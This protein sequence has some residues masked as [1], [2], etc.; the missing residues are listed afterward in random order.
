[1]KC[2]KYIHTIVAILS[3]VIFVVFL[4]NLYSPYIVSNAIEYET[5]I[6]PVPGNNRITSRFGWRDLNGDGK[7][8][9]LHQAI[10][11]GC[12]VGTNV[13]AVASGKVV[14]VQD[15]SYNYGMGRRL[16]I[17]HGNSI[18]TGYQHLSKILVKTGDVV[19]QGDVIALSGNTG[20]N[21][22]PHLDFH[23]KINS[24]DDINS[25]TNHFNKNPLDNFLPYE[26]SVS[27][28]GET[29]YIKSTP[30][31]LPKYSEVVTPHLNFSGYE[32]LPT[33]KLSLG[34]SYPVKGIISAYPNINHVWGGV[35]N[36][37]GSKTA[38]YCDVTINASTYNLATYFDNNIIFNK[39]PV[40][41]Y[42]YKIE[43]TTTD[44][45]HK[46]IQ[47]EFQ[48]GD[49]PPEKKWY[50]TMTPAN[51]ANSFD[52]I[53]LNKHYWIPIRTISSTN[54]VLHKEEG[55]TSEMWRFTRQSD[56]SYKIENFGNG[57]CLDAWGMGTANGTN[58]GSVASNN[59]QAQR[60]FIYAVNG[61][62][63]FRPAYGELAMDLNGNNNADNTNIQLWTYHG[64]DAQVF[65]IYDNGAKPSPKV[66]KANAT[67]NSS[68]S[69][70]WD[71]TFYTDKYVVYRS[72]DNTNWKKLGE[73]TSTSYTDNGLSA[74]TKYYYKYESVN[75]FY[76]VSSPSVAVTT[77][78][79]PEYTVTFD[80]NG[81]SCSPT[82]KVVRVGNAYGD[83]P[84]ATR[85]GYTFNGWYTEKNGG[86]QVTKDTKMNTAKNHT[87]YAHWTANQYTLIV[88]PNGGTYDNSTS[89]VTKSPKLIYDSG[90]WYS[91]G[92]ATRTGY[93]LIGYFT[94]ATGGT[95]VYD[96]NG[97]C[98]E[99]DFWKDNK[100]K[101]T[102]NLTVYAQWS[103]I[104]NI[105]VTLNPNGGTCSKDSITVVYDGKYT[106]LVNADRKG[107]TFDGWY[108]ESGA[109]VTTDT[110]VKNP[111]AHTLYAHWTAKNIS[112]NFYR[113][114]DEND[115]GC[116]T[117]TFT[118][119]VANQRFGYKTD[120]TG[121]Y[122]PMNDEKVGFG[123]WTKTGYQLLGWSTQRN[124]SVNYSTYSG[125]ANDWI[126]SNSP[127]INLYAQWKANQY[128]VKLDANGGTVSSESITVTYDGTY[129]DLPD[130][131]Q[132]GYNFNGWFT[133]NGTQISNTDRVTIVSDLTLYAH[134]SQEKMLISFNAN[135]GTSETAK[136]LVTFD[137]KYGA[138]PNAT[139]TGYTFEGWYLDEKFTNLI[140]ES[141]IVKIT[142]NQAV[143]AKWNLQ[144][145]TVK[146]DANGGTAET[147]GKQ[148]IFSRTYGVLPIAEKEN[149]VFVGWFT[150][151][152][153]EIT[154]D[155]VV[156]IDK[157]ITLY[158][159]WQSE[160]KVE[161]DVNSDSVLDVNDV[162]VLNNYLHHK[163]S[164]TKEMFESADLNGDGKI[165]VID[166]ALLK[167][168]ILKGKGE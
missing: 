104:G 19:S 155:T 4:G 145:F 65:S 159:K 66:P 39:L 127:S 30:Y 44:G 112:V 16:V 58:I 50:E 84:N 152:G 124:S 140:T 154:P 88:N 117:E 161:G 2:K 11:I 130:P 55:I 160:I 125:V 164:F 86:S 64:Q 135:G 57:L 28:N 137:T 163:K 42:V 141:S 168:L 108:T 15:D 96:A 74:S 73:T 148:V 36:R 80:A 93:N 22:A 136:K 119:D 99:S 83:L 106:G 5:V 48:I 162:K 138:L 109:K 69:V 17:Y 94:S 115:T 132:T 107:Y 49:P 87:L 131:T 102:G 43:A 101:N 120:G 114:L 158:A 90:N 133:E 85:T 41:Y 10:D 113:N 31:T 35:Y 147:S 116:V 3:C 51:L 62:Y 53:I 37:D 153:K 72:T 139:K 100:Y 110:V 89:A 167:Q 151:D 6:W 68:V 77:N 24:G 79:N 78:A 76:T 118:Y 7:N 32:S 40:G 91:I 92:K 150:E 29:V 61:G 45:Q 18:Y 143:Y 111:S 25:V 54:V 156:T 144:K 33:G 95:K 142:K 52:S 146:F 1:M 75:R 56:G 97:N 121:R 59:S 27:T 38:Q 47:S 165:N 9:D 126:N 149:D 8:D 34:K 82:S 134:W 129:S 166:L 20:G 123:G 21:Y 71:K 81:G 14:L 122:S 26:G 103:V 70:N 46:S 128:T 98:V 63:V 12:P 13:L 60:W 105:K 157:N 23:V 67:S